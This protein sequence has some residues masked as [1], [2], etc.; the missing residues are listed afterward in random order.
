LW[1]LRFWSGVPPRRKTCPLGFELDSSRPEGLVV[2]SLTLS[3]VAL[4]QVLGDEYGIQEIRSGHTAVSKKQH[5]GSTKQFAR[6]AASHNKG[7]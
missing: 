6:W 7:Q 4:D 3:G 2:V 5:F 1:L